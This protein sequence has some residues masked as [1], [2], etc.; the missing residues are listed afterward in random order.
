VGHRQGKQPLIAALLSSHQQSAL[1]GAFSWA[2]LAT[3]SRHPARNHESP[4]CPPGIQGFAQARHAPQSGINPGG[5]RPPDFAAMARMASMRETDREWWQQ[6]TDEVSG[7]EQS[8]MQHSSFLESSHTNRRVPTRT[9]PRRRAK[10]P[11]WV[12]YVVALIV[13]AVAGLMFWL[14]HWH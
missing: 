11:T 2:K 8:S 12:I 5:I 7:F 13:A 4:L 9:R 14:P 6:K 10:R 1:R 3:C